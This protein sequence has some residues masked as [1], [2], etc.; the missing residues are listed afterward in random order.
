MAGTTG[1]RYAVEPL[2]CG[3]CGEPLADGD[4]VGCARHLELEPPRYC[5]VC[6]RR[7]TVQ[8][9]PGAWT[10]TCSRHGVTEQS[11]WGPG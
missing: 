10:A 4:H 1:D 9:V 5:A 3:R 8:V 2:W 6:R 11:T 7:M